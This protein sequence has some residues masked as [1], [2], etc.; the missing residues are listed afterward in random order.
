MN[1]Y[2]LWKYLLI[3]IVLL[4]G[5]IYT[6]PNF[7]GTAPAVQVSANHAN[8]LLTAA[9]E[10]KIQTALKQA[11]LASQSIEKIDNMIRVQFA[12]NES[13]IKAKDAI[14]GVFGSGY[15]VALNLVPLTPKWLRDIGA[16]P[17]A[18]GL[19]LRGGVHFLLEVDKT[20]ALSK[21]LEGYSSDI[22]RTL[23]D[24][25]IRVGGV[26]R[27]GEVIEVKTRD[28][29]SMTAVQTLIKQKIPGL[30]LRTDAVA[31]S[32]VASLSPSEKLRVQSEAVEQNRLTLSKRVNELGVAE[33]V[34]QQHGADSIA[35]EL[36]GIQDIGSARNILGRTATLEV[37]LVDDERLADALAGNIP[38]DS[39]LIDEVRAEG[40]TPILVKRQVELTG[41]NINDA[42]PSFDEQGKPSINL[43]LD[44][45]GADIFKEVTK[46]NIGR[47][48]A[49]IL[50]ENG[51]A[52]AVTAPV[53]RDEIGG[54][55]VE[56]SGSMDAKEA[57][58]TSLLL[59]SGSLKAPM[60]I[61]EERT[62]GPSLGA[63][64]IKK[65]FSSTQYGFM[66]VSIFMILYYRFFGL[67]S[68]VALAAN[69]LLL[70][71]LLSLLQAT[72]TLPGIA[73]IALALGMAIDS[74]VLINERIREEVHL[75]VSPHTAIHKGYE[76]AWATIVDSNITTLIAGIGLFSCGT[77]P[78][79][80]FAV[81]H[82]LG[83]MT[84]MFSAVL[85][86]RALVNL[87]HGGRKLKKLWV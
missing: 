66:L 70:I 45:V 26:R 76:H 82:C 43:R 37:R 12:N 71:A 51:V 23:K 2:P 48:M 8:L 52:Q 41:D 85:V 13:Q 6:I 1:K 47:R 68:V 55:R 81:V 15:T 27:I 54:G 5:L 42:Q 24:K 61:V 3:G 77:G 40:V 63:E 67:I 49:M 59:R 73:A 30:T 28:A 22:R 17:M 39:E 83:I 44:A 75:G 7:F 31:F 78:V 58:D 10:G 74:N 16:K 84:S 18:L 9:D 11:G 87:T 4:F 64:N 46:E 62:V 53:I 65:G 38:S 57:K 14:Q 32:V 21:T 79:K 25:G 20:A 60:K 50:V 19:D 80:G 34:I 33:P 36:P 35:V 72:L 86:S 69:L 29:E 56:I